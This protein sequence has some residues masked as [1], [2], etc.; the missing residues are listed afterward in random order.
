MERWMVCVG[1]DRDCRHWL[2]VCSQQVHCPMR[3]R[4][5]P[6]RITRNLR[7]KAI[8]KL[9]Q[10]EWPLSC[11]SETKRCQRNLKLE[12]VGQAFR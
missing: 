6:D 5:R 1:E 11:L 4:G 7:D 9:N 10:R 3:L 2:S 8:D 12:V